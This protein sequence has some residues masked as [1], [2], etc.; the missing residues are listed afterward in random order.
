MFV[1]N[2][3]SDTLSVISGGSQQSVSPTPMVPEFGGVMV[4][5]VLIVLAFFVTVQSVNSEKSKI[6]IAI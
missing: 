1:A 2:R 6:C 5:L 4:I 3:D